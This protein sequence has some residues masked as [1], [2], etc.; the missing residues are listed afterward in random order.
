MYWFGQSLGVSP[1]SKQ[2][3]GQGRIGVSAGAQPQEGTI[4]WQPWPGLQILPPRSVALESIH[5]LRS[6]LTFGLCQGIESGTKEASDILQSITMGGT[7]LEVT[8]VA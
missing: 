5:R 4:R 7:Q 6:T 8:T 3:T 2:V 1:W